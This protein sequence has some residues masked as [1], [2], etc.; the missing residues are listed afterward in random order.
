MKKL[1]GEFVRCII[2]TVLK[3]CNLNKVSNNGRNLR[4]QYNT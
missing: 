3:Q 2:I 1:H 4:K